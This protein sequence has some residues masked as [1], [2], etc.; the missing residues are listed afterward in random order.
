[1][2]SPVKVIN[3][4]ETVSHARKVMMRE[5]LSRL[6]V[7][8]GTKPVGTLTRHD[9]VLG[10]NNY[11]MRQRDLDSIAV[12]EMMRPSVTTV[13]EVESVIEA[14]K[15]MALLN[16]KGLPVVDGAGDL[17]G[18][19]TKTDLTRYFAENYKGRYKVSDICQSKENLAIIQPTHSVSRAADLMKE[20]PIDRVIVVDGNMPVGVI[21]ETDIQ[22]MDRK[23]FE[24]SFVKGGVKRGTREGDEFS[25]TRIY[26]IPTA[27]DIMTR[28]P[29]TI[30]G[31]KDAAEAAETLISKDIGGMPVV[32]KKGELVGMVTKFDFVKL[33]AK[34]VGK[35]NETD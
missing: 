26:L 14:A 33:L 11:N 9:L 29:T 13:N 8:E 7:V 35:D 24:R 20:K 19:I 1:M 18:I 34:E 6:I 10:L 2:Q 30:V 32:D 31:S 28:D 21:T 16:I 17:V 15:K 4:V 3:K 27:E 12:E 5:K 25:H 22:S 23:P